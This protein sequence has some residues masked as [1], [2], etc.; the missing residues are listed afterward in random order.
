VL[1]IA[2]ATPLAAVTGVIVSRLYFHEPVKEN[3]DS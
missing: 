3:S 2:L 1:G